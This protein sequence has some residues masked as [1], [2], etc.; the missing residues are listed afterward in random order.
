MVWRTH[1]KNP[2][3]FNVYEIVHLL[4]SQVILDGWMSDMR[5]EQGME[6]R[7]H[8]PTQKQKNML[9]YSLMLWFLSQ[10]KQ[11]AVSPLTSKS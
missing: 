2:V 10:V 1:S 6:T 11:L 4:S 9:T 8:K 3:K 5:G 7:E